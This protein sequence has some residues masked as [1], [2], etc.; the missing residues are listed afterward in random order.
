MVVLLFEKRFWGPISNG[1]KV[2]S[3]RPTRKRPIAPGDELSLRGWKGSPYRSKQEVIRWA[4]CIDVRQIWIDCYGITIE[5]YERIVD[6]EDLDLFARTDGFAD[7]QDMR[8][9]R[10]LFY[11][12]PFI[13]HFIQ[14]APNE[15]LTHFERG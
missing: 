2:H 10:N 1:D 3:I 5:G 11:Q 15:F 12:L 4:T 13:G 6:S 14:W 7:W 9:Y 8:Q